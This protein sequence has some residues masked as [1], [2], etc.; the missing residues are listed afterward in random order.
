MSAVPPS[1]RSSGWE[2]RSPLVPEHP[3]GSAREAPGE[4][5]GLA[6]S[7]RRGPQFE[8]GGF[9][10]VVVAPTLRRPPWSWI[11]IVTSTEVLDPKR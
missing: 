11:V 6:A 9:S 3:P 7:F 5:H 8:P 2:T 4:H 10:I 1:S